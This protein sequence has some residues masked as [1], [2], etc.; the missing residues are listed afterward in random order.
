MII[1]DDKQVVQLVQDIDRLMYVLIMIN[2][3]NRQELLILD[4][5]QI[6][7]HQSIPIIKEE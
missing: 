4:I 6:L 3:Q 1:L 5:P 2:E 7:L